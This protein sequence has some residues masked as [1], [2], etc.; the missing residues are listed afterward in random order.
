MGEPGR[1]ERGKPEEKKGEE[2]TEARA[3]A[4]SDR[5]HQWLVVKVLSAR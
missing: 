5:G 2:P 4:V 1:K 3:E